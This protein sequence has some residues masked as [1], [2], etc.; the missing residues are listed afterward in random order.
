MMP[1]TAILCPAICIR[2]GRNMDMQAVYSR[3][4]ALR[5]EMTAEL[6]AAVRIPS[7]MGRPRPEAP[8]GE[9]PRQM[10]EHFLVRAAGMSCPVIS[11]AP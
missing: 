6:A 1:E 9:G 2:E 10:L 11:P 5:E 3:I 8:S 4:D 7:V